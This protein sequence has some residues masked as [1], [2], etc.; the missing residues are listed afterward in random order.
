[1]IKAV[2]LDVGGVL[3]KQDASAI[4]EFHDREM[5]W[6]DGSSAGIWKEYLDAAH[7][8]GELLPGYRRNSD[9]ECIKQRLYATNRIVSGMGELVRE[10]REVCRLAVLSN[11]TADLNQVLEQLGL[12]LSFELIVNFALVGVKKPDA[13][14]YEIAC[15]RLSVEPGEAVFIDDNGANVTAAQ[16]MGM[17][18]IVFSSAGTLRS[19]LYAA[20]L[21]LRHL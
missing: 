7:I 15:H 14:I 21:A 8:G 6:A 10:L 19:E 5:E 16:S 9:V 4:F 1:M 11:F 2:F 20:G 18:G 3:L 13:K 12:L 17:Q